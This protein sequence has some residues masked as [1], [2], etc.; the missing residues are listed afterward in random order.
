MKKTLSET[1]PLLASEWHPSNNLPLTPAD[2]TQGSGRKVWWICKLGH[3]WEASIESRNRGNGCPACAGKRVHMDN[4]LMKMHPQ[5]ASEWHPSKNPGI[6]PDNVT[7]G[8]SRKV[9]WL[10][11]IGH[12]WQAIV[13][14]RTRGSGCPK[15]RS[16]SSLMELRILAELR[17]VF[18][19][20]SHRSKQGKFEC[21]CFLPHYNVAVEYDGLRWHINKIAIDEAKNVGLKQNGIDCVRIRQAGLPQ[22]GP[23]DLIIEKSAMQT[24][25]PMQRLLIEICSLRELLPKDAERVREY[26][27]QETWANEAGYQ[28]LLANHPYPLVGL[29]LL[30]KYP[31]I[32]HSWHPAKN[33]QLTPAHVHPQSGQSVWWLCGKGHTWK[34]R[35]SHRVTGSGCPICSG[36]KVILETSLAELLPLVA[37]EWDFQKNTPLRPDEVTPRSVRSVWWR[38]SEGHEWRTTVASRARSSICPHCT[39]KLPIGKIDLASQSPILSRQWYE[40]RNGRLKP[41][42][43]TT[44]S[45]RNVWWKC[46]EGHE[47]QATVANRV[48]GSGCPVCYGRVASDRHNLLTVYPEIAHE[49]HPTRNA[50]LRPSDVTPGSHRKVWWRCHYGHEWQADAHCRTNAGSGCPY[51]A[52]K[53][54]ASNNSLESKYPDLAKQWHPMRNIPLSPDRVTCG[55]GIVVWWRCPKQ[56]EWCAAISHRVKGSGCPFCAGRHATPESSLATVYPEL[57][58]QWHSTKNPEISP[59]DVTKGSTKK[60]WWICEA[61]HEWQATVGHRVAGRGCPYCAGK[62][63][64]SE[65]SLSAVHPNLIAEWHLSKNG[66]LKPSDVTPGISKP[67]WWQCSHG[68]EWRTRIAHRANGSGCPK[69]AKANRIFPR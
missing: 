60:V 56:H 43:V 38:C 29:S 62:K 65:K 55:S 41:S 45:S 3:E 40:T 26:L 66:T 59:S 5:L 11:P 21:D 44:G 2:V 18:V 48:K 4:S 34:A 25:E 33:K 6:S 24:I 32:A 14:S 57:A 1:N 52:G 47:W 17:W 49:W 28:S 22:I 54:V 63:V 19:D 10:C 31:E 39:R 51:C 61:G 36:Y 64:S 46:D 13:Y 7:S 42:D 9:W 20:V 35:I 27:S 8:S 53:R 67:V 58:K 30:D 23:H 68:H 69:C 37:A 12:E 16:S 15:C 50:E